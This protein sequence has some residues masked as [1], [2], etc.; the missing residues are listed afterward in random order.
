MTV[1]MSVDNQMTRFSETSDQQEYRP[2][3]DTVSGSKPTVLQEICRPD[4]IEEASY[5]GRRAV[6]T[7]CLI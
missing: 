3:Q 1:Y 5:T 4:T 6:L 2:T 7:W